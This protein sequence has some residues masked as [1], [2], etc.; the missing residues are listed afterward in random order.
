MSP[1]AAP[2]VSSVTGAPVIGRDA[3]PL[4]AP[5]GTLE[6]RSEPLGGSPL[7]RAAQVGM[8]PE[9]WFEPVPASSGEWLRRVG[10]VREQFAAGAWLELLAPAFD[11]HGR[12]AERLQSVAAGAGVIV[13]TG[14]QPGLFGGPLYTL[15]KALGARALADVLE[16]ST[17][18]PVAP[19]FWA[20]TDDADFA[21]ASHTI[22]AG[23]HGAVEL[24][25][26]STAPEGTPM[27]AVP[28]G[29]DVIPLLETL[30]GAAGSVSYAPALAA[31][32]AAYRSG[33]TVGGAYVAL[34]RALLEPLGI[35]VLDASHEATREASFHLLRR[36]L[37]QAA[38]IERAVAKRGADIRA[39]GFTPQVEE[40][41]GLSLVFRYDASGR[42]ARVPVA[43]ARAL[44]TRVKHHELGPN[45]LLRPVVERTILPTVAYAAGP[46]ELSYFAQVSAVAGAL[47]ASTPLA[48]PRWSG[49]VIEPHVRRALARLGI[50]VDDLAAP[51]A[52]EG[53]RARA[54][55]PAD[56]RAALDGLR[57]DVDGRVDALRRAE[58]GRASVPAPVL[59]GARNALR[60]RIDRLE[61]RYLAALKRRDDE[62]ARDF[63]TARAA[64]YPLGKRQERA[65]NPVP[66]LARHGPALWEA[67]LARARAHAT[68]LVER[69]HPPRHDG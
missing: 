1:G 43:D 30:R 60:H 26:T 31:V 61:R 10:R 49:T 24:R 6:V 57:A 41:A 29:D 5:D 2:R 11:A 65:L 56:V 58:D 12:A 36:A 35:A 23:P 42:K 66:L 53:R 45:V 8:A 13:T 63:T 3:T 59:D 48:V 9:G 64:L 21:E 33:A 15:S 17:G 7:S 52:A 55:M 47:G 28:L 18:I 27:S 16:E 69:G 50:D 51:D 67:M 37:L 19:V 68:S 34:M 44:V 20:A 38:D 14:Q 40:V 22:V 46:G 25:A 39:A 4:A 62:A 32:E 54:R